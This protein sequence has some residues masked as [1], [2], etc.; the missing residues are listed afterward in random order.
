[1]DVERSSL[2]N[3]V[4]NFLIEENYLLTAFELL[5]ELLDDGRD[6]QAI[7]LKQLFSDPAQ[8]P[9]DQIARFNSLR[10]A[11]PQ[12]L[13]E[14]REAL[15]EKLAL[16]EYELRLA[17]EDTRKLKDE[18]LKKSELT[19]DE[20][21]GS[22]ADVSTNNGPDSQQAKRETSYS[23]LGPLKDNERRDVNCA[24]K[25]Y[26][27]LAGYRLTAMTFYEEVTGQ[28]L[29]NWDN[30]NACVPDA[31]RH[32]YYQYLSSTAEAAEEK[33]AMLRENESLQKEND[34]LKHEKTTL[35]KS[36]D[37]A[38]GQV[39]ALT[40]S[41]ETLQKDLKDKEI[42][43]QS[44][45]QSLERQRKELN[46]C[47]AEITSLKMHI[48]GSRS[49]RSLLA[50]DSEHMQSGSLDNYKE[51]IKLLQK[52]IESLKTRK[53]IMEKSNND[54]SEL[55]EIKDKVV[56]V[57]EDNAVMSPVEITSGVPE[58]VG[59]QALE[60]ENSDDT[61]DKPE[62]LTGETL[63][64]FPNGNGGA[65]GSAEN[66]HEHD[67]ESLPVDNGQ[68]LKSDSLGI[69]SARE[70]IGFETIQILSDALPKI[71]PYV[72]I[73]HREEL[74][75]LI[76]CAIER[77]PESSTRDS[78][79]H[80][81]F[82]LIKRPDE[83]QRRIIM[84]ACVTLAKNVGEMRTE[85]ELLP[86][87]WE[88]INHMYEER[89]LLVAQSCG[90]LAEFVRPEIRDSLILSIMQQLIEDSGTVVR[91][92]AAHNLA[93]L[94]PLFPN[95]DKYFKVEE[96]MFQLVCDPSGVVVDTTIK[97][98]VPSLVKWG[99]KLDHILRVLLSHIISSAQRCPPLS[100][101]EGSVESHLRVL[102]ERERWN[103]DVLLRL[104]E[105][106]LPFVHRKAIETCPFPSHSENAGTLFSTSLLEQY[107][108]DYAE[109]PAFEWLHTDCLP[110]LIRLASLLP[111]KEDTLRNRITKA[112][113]YTFSF[114][115]W[116]FGC[117]WFYHFLLAV[118]ESFGDDYLTHIMLPVFLVA[119]GDNADFKFLPSTIQSRIRG[120]RPKTAVAERLAAMCVLPL[121]LAGVL[122]SP[123]KQKQLTDY[124]SN[125]LFQSAVQEGQPSKHHAEIV[126]PVRFLCTFEEHH[127]MIFNILWE[128]VVSSDV[129]MKI[130][131]ANLFKVSV[132]YI[133]AKVAST[134][135]VP[136]LITLGSD[137]NLNVKYGS[138]DA[139]GAVAQH[140]KND[141][142]VDKIRVQMDAFLE[143]GS[144]EAT[145]AVVR[146]LVVAVP[147]TTDR[148][149]DYILN[150][151]F[152]INYC[153]F[154]YSE[155]YRPCTPFP[156]SDVR[157][158]RERANAFCESIRALDATDLPANSVRDLLLPT[159]QN[160]LKDPDALDPAH[161]EAL[162]IVMK[163]RGGGTFEAI[164]KVM[165]AHLGLASS[166]SSFF[167]EGGLL[168]KKETGDPSPPPPEPQVESPKS[169]PPQQSP[170]EDTRFRRIMR[171][172]FS[173]MLRGKT[174]SSEENPPSQ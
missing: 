33:I 88:Q 70:K 78:L 8:F 167:G 48:E 94:L 174:K 115:V 98:L 157:R 4:V 102:G 51:E 69:E 44:L 166:V 164:S 101:V 75:P 131:A 134:H 86:Q 24:V 61:S 122:G 147:H 83:Q 3:C 91:E 170:V 121:L 80:T 1:M 87:C 43:V 11:D 52:E 84:A 90:E 49:G 173:D 56:D 146:A 124:L 35:L 112:I 14:E 28:N 63:V 169:V 16:T 114:A 13:L 82:N 135:V 31:L 64:I 22:N 40:R 2:C 136:A 116:Q 76:M 139:F 5:H 111:Q 160:L 141:M 29:D 77:H 171:G 89:R 148:L 53:Y 42:L 137:Q 143:D 162:E 95:L 133:D 154:T 140:F 71:V 156:T 25:E 168:G 151:F 34:K 73:N 132:P 108:G 145:I 92:A 110:D 100:G 123:S 165:G 54:D 23:D 106:L 62:A 60:N 10:V 32:Y 21:T 152:L 47:R 68:P 36:K 45:K 150:P 113:L 118:S 129:N 15:A 105:E 103:V 120:L 30:S 38:D 172:G 142:I 55:I 18:L 50:G 6:A 138:I 163:E 117:F 93:L 104:L 57:Q 159:I 99:D 37:V 79:T 109:W 41:L 19:I 97:E 155:Y 96:M 130:S 26:L 126:N 81:L 7:R 149:R 158:R 107:A 65:I 127:N 144:H 161:K 85:T 12:S 27:L 72:L 17:Q 9:P 20:F 39:T 59:V 74:L 58:T 125:L 119:V 46:D 67:G 66:I 153:G 128:M